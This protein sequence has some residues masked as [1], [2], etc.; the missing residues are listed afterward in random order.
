MALTIAIDDTNYDIVTFGGN[1]KMLTGADAVGQ[2][3]VTAMRSVLGEMQYAK[4][5]GMPYFQVAFNNFNPVAFE[6]SARR[7]IGVVE[8]VNKIEQFSVAVTDNVLRYVAVIETIYG[9]TTINGQ[10]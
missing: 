5:S 6:A 10:S 9:Q 7:V 8:G 4:L 1:I 2:N 3:C